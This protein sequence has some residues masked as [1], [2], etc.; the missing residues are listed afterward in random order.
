MNLNDRER[1]VFKRFG[2]NE[3]AERWRLY[4]TILLY[5]SIKYLHS[6]WNGATTVC[7]LD[8]VGFNNAAW[9]ESVAGGQAAV[10]GVIGEC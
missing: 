1:K 9:N 2:V 8:D 5:S 3:V 6:S 7:V 10:S 4:L